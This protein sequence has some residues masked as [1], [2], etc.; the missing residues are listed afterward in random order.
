MGNTL[1]ELRQSGQLSGHN[2]LYEY[3]SDRANNA[4]F[5]IADLLSGLN[6]KK[7]PNIYDIDLLGSVDGKQIRGEIERDF[8]TKRW[9]D[10]DSFPY[11]LINI[12]IEKMH[13]F[14][15]DDEE[16]MFYIKTSGNLKSLFIL[17]CVDIVAHSKKEVL[18]SNHD[19]QVK[20]RIFYRIPTE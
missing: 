3:D 12:P 17:H 10:K 18:S 13:Y 6:F 14:T 9:I 2:G 19:G 16:R 1:R 4:E 20:D 5:F 15:E 11:P 7:N 8:A